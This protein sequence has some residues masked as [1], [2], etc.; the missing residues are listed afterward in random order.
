MPAG[1][2]QRTSFPQMIRRLRAGWSPD[3][4]MPMRIELQDRLD[5]L[6]H[7]IRRF[8]NSKLRCSLA[9]SA[10]RLHGGR[11]SSQRARHGSIPG[12]FGIA[13]KEQVKTLERAWTKYREVHQQDIE[14]KIHPF[15]ACHNSK[16][17]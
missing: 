1:D 4:S 15:S 9:R 7:Q 3:M 17:E 12:R 2:R 10:A 14:G 16:S 13:S 5:E 11:A 8:G 6:L